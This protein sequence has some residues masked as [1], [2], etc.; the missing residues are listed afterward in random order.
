MK[1]VIIEKTKQF[2]AP[3]KKN[4]FLLFKAPKRKR[5]QPKKISMLRANMSILGQMYIA[6][7]SREGDLEEFFAHESQNFPPSLAVNVEKM[8]HSRKSNVLDCLQKEVNAIQ[9][10]DDVRQTLVD[11]DAVVLDGGALIHSLLPRI[12]VSNFENY[13]DMCFRKHIENELRKTSRVDVVWDSYW[14]CSIKGETRNNRGSSTGV[15]LKIGPKVKLPNNWSN[16]LKLP[17]NKVELFNFLTETAVSSLELPASNLYITS[18]DI[19]QHVGPGND[20]TEKCDH[21]EADT[22]I[23]LHVMH[24]LN[25]GATNVWCAQW[26]QM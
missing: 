15:R 21:E 10:L 23:V 18:G 8:Y 16:F 25:N 22:R 24:A 6:T 5:D 3:I 20:M 7:Q 4:A 19:V 26:T 9:S 11:Y 2:D 13:F 14:E 17:E 1:E 12:G